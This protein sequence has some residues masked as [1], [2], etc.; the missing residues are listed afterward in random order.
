MAPTAPRRFRHCGQSGG[1]LMGDATLDTSK[2]CYA[3]LQQ[4]KPCPSA[5]IDAWTARLVVLRVFGP[6]FPLSRYRM[7]RCDEYIVTSAD[8]FRMQLCDEHSGWKLISRISFCI[9]NP[10]WLRMTQVMRV[11]QACAWR[12]LAHDAR[13]WHGLTFAQPRK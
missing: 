11:A 7:Q 2:Q 4:S 6:W 5:I 12:K 9:C 10:R 3:A 8:T 13:E 1:S